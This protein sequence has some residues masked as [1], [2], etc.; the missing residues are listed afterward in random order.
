MIKGKLTSR[1]RI[2]LPKEVRAALDVRDG[3][4]LA[5]EIESH[6]VVMTKIDAVHDSIFCEWATEAD[7]VAFGKL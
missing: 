6:R 3:D 7:K 2:T 4:T 5:Y 1:N